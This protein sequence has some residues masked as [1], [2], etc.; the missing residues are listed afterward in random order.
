MEICQVSICKRADLPLS[1]F[2]FAK[3]TTKATR[4]IKSVRQCHS[5]TRQMRKL[6]LSLLNSR[7]AA[8]GRARRAFCSSLLLRECTE[9]RGNDKV[10]DLPGRSVVCQHE[11]HCHCLLRMRKTG[12]LLQE[13]TKY[14]PHHNK[15]IRDAGKEQ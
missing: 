6:S 1:N 8:G 15:K 11:G 14:P 4:E 3:K 5:V 2:A 12:A 13:V 7:W 10:K 9:I